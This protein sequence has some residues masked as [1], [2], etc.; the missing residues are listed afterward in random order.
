MRASFAEFLMRWSCFALHLII[1]TY[2]RIGKDSLPQKMPPTFSLRKGTMRASFAV[3]LMRWSCFTLHLII[4]ASDCFTC[5]TSSLLKYI[6]HCTSA[7]S[8]VHCSVCLLFPIPFPPLLSMV[9][10]TAHTMHAHPWGLLWLFLCTLLPE[11]QFLILGVHAQVGLPY[12]VSVPVCLRLPAPL[13]WHHRLQG[14][15]R[16]LPMA[17]LLGRHR[18]LKGLSETIAFTVTRMQKA[19]LLRSK[20]TTAPH[21]VCAALHTVETSARTQ[22]S[23]CASKAATSTKRAAVMWTIWD[24]VSGNQPYVGGSDFEIWVETVKTVGLVE[25]RFFARSMQ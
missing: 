19:T 24:C 3:F 21:L 15:Q 17:V 4:A 23:R 6:V 22:R 16:A 18:F 9:T 20:L 5:S 10:V 8:R 7:T 2:E 14:S 11:R 13:L 1:A 12:W 25:L